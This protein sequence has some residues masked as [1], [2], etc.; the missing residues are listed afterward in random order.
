MSICDV[1]LI[2]SPASLDLHRHPPPIGPVC[3]PISS[4]GSGFAPLP[5]RFPQEITTFFQFFPF[6]HKRELGF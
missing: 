5:S 4:V 3:L 2:I 6:S 1:Q